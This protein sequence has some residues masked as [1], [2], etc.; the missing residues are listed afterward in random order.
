MK[1]KI[2]LLVFILIGL[3]SVKSS[4][5]EL[6]KFFD[7][8]IINS[9]NLPKEMHRII[10]EFLILE[11]KKKLEEIFSFKEN[12]DLIIG[13]DYNGRPRNFKITYFDLFQ[14]KSNELFKNL[15]EICKSS[16]YMTDIVLD[17]IS[18]IIKI[19]KHEK[20]NKINIA[21]ILNCVNWLE[22]YIKKISI[23]NN[24][25]EKWD[26][27]I[28]PNKFGLYPVYLAISCENIE[29]LKLLL[30]SESYTNFHN[31]EFQNP[32]EYALL[33][34]QKN[35]L[36][37]YSIEKIIKI[38]IENGTN[39]IINKKYPNHF[40]LLINSIAH[41]E[42]NK[43]LR[44]I[45]TLLKQLKNDKDTDKTKLTNLENKL[46]GQFSDIKYKLSKLSEDQKH[47]FTM[48][49]IDNDFQILKRIPEFAIYCSFI[50]ITEVIFLLILQKF[51][52]QKT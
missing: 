23:N 16:I 22:K 35:Y 32:L 48:L 8:E 25:S 26:A 41:N 28:K 20:N 24:I 10:L 30:K 17:I 7:Q 4:C 14:V 50:I 3:F 27:L 52:N 38:L 40:K 49:K 31:K 9:P 51:D 5:M 47:E 37:E 44:N 42:N 6:D 46:N 13:K 29:V 43:K 36:M 18:N 39:L 1:I 34:F 12:T 19:S 33:L 11:D 21:I 2:N 45:E 15:K